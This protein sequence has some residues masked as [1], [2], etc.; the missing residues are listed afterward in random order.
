MQRRAA[1]SCELHVNAP[2]KHRLPSPEGLAAVVLWGIS[3]VA[4]RVALES[5]HP[6]GLIASR[7]LLGSAVLLTLQLAGRRTLLPLRGDRLR[8][9]LLGAILG[10]HLLL[11]AFGLL[12]TTAIQTGWI[13]GVIPVM[14][15]LGGRM[16][17][18]KRLAPISWLGIGVGA[19]G[20]AVVTATRIPEFENAR[21]GDLLQLVSC[22]T[23]TI[24]T[25]AADRPVSR[26]GPLRTTASAMVVA[27]VLAVSVTPATGWL[28]PDALVDG[29]AVAASCTSSRSSR[30]ALRSRS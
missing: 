14:I 1:A 19:T 24:Y 20:V 8:C 9:A 30:S 27:A 17:L 6:V 16:F 10:G 7:L 25:L 22:V 4:T 28:A 26:S 29:E 13:I 3:F 12:H 5:F 11:Q 2:P 23:W 21:F 15:A 18:G